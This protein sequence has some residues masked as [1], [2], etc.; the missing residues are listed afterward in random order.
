MLTLSHGAR[1]ILLPAV[2]AAAF[3]ALSA[4]IAHADDDQAPQPGTS[5]DAATA[6]GPDAAPARFAPENNTETDAPS[7]PTAESDPAQ[8]A[9]LT[10]D[11]EPDPAAP[12]LRPVVL[13]PAPIGS[14][15]LPNSPDPAEWKSA[16]ASAPDVVTVADPIPGPAP[17]RTLVL[18]QGRTPDHP[19]VYATSIDKSAIIYTP[20]P[21]S[22]VTDDDITAG[23][24]QAGVN[25]RLTDLFARA[26][27]TII[28]GESGGSTNAVNRWDSNARGGRRIDG[29]PV[30]SSRGLM[31]T[32]PD[33]FAAFHAPGT[34]TAIYDP[35]ANIAAAWRYVSAR[36][37]VNLDSGMGL[38]AFMSRGVGHGVGY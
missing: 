11:T 21:V 18:T 38:G 15:Q 23:L 32:V 17:S 1:R 31:Q 4:G 36:Y 13:V 26:T 8:P 34:S 25:P 14:T 35:V 10:S 6:S 5:S 9:L 33:T 27:Q 19:A 22:H 29:A 16:L 12:A 37:G 7:A 28:G 24:A 3:T 30:G 20:H 2:A